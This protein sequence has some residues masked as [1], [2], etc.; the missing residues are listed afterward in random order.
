MSEAELQTAT[1]TAT[2]TEER[3]APPK[4]DRMPMW[5]VLLHNDKVN[6]MVY[7]VETIVALTHLHRNDA[8]QRMFEAHHKGLALLATTHQEHAELLEEQFRSK[9]L[10]VTIEPEG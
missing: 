9:R 3:T 5:R 6:E 1:A 2:A 8:V 10:R 4:L 7:V